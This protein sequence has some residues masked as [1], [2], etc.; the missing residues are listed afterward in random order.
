MHE[1]DWDW[2]NNI[3]KAIP[4]FSDRTFSRCSLAKNMYAERPRF[5]AFGSLGTN[6]LAFA[7]IEFASCLCLV[8]VGPM[9]F[10]HSTKITQANIGC[11]TAPPTLEGLP[12]VGRQL[13][14]RQYLDSVRQ[15]GD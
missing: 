15:K 8:T 1:G 7:A 10:F 6:E 11:I 13:G 12:V 3:P 5:G 9:H 4:G 2:G 14:T